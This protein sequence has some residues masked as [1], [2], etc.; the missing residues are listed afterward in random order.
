VK[1]PEWLMLGIG[2]ILAVTLIWLALPYRAHAAPFHQCGIAS[3]Y[4][5][6]SGTR[7]ANGERFP[8]REA[9]AAHKTLPFGTIVTVT[10]QRT[11]R[12]I[13][14]RINDRGPF[15]KGRIIDLS[16]AARRGLGMDGLSQVCIRAP[17]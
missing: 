11:G 2:V 12:S 7:T 13:R 8:T 17:P 14:V 15:V 5:T 16:P 9:T 3:W 10:D 4:G 6:E 1:A